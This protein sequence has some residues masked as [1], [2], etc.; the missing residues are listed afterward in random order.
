MHASTLP[1]SLIKL[2]AALIEDA[3][4]LKDEN[5]SL[6]AEHYTFLAR[7]TEKV[8]T[9]ASI[10]VVTIKPGAFSAAMAAPANRLNN[11]T[12]S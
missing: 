1:A 9:S 3:I 5:G 8:S 7:V 12:S 11:M 6:I 10:V 2:E 4:S